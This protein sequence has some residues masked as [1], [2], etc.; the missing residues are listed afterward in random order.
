MFQGKH[1]V[2]CCH[3]AVTWLCFQLVTR[4]RVLLIF[5]S[6]HGQFH[7]VSQSGHSNNFSCR[8]FNV[9]TAAID[10]TQCPYWHP[11]SPRPSPGYLSVPCIRATKCCPEV[12]SG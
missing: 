3:L 1:I 10:V 6:I 11:T 9:G 8:L 7:A 2:S 12:T 5:G 4:I